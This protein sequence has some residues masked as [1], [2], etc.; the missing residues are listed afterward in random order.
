M[1]FRANLAHFGPKFN[2][3]SLSDVGT[4]GGH[5]ESDIS[6]FCKYRY[7]RIEGGEKISIFRYLEK[8]NKNI[9]KH[10]KPHKKHTN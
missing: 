10:T 9:T 6:K 2:I 8:K 3:N 1:Q 4:S 5:I 7:C